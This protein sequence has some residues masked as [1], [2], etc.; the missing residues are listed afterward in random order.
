MSLLK[1]AIIIGLAIYLKTLFKSNMDLLKKTMKNYFKDFPYYNKIEDF[2]LKHEN[3]SDTTLV[4]IF[5]ILIMI[6]IF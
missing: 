4:L 5:I 2:L 6:I 1:T 3:I